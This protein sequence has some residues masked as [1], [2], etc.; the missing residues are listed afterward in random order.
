M[1]K[2]MLIL[3]ASIFWI[4][5][6]AFSQQQAQAGG[7]PLTLQRGNKTTTIKPGRRMAVVGPAEDSVIRGKLIT[8]TDSIA[9]QLAERGYTIQVSKVAVSDVREI[10]RRRTGW[11]LVGFYF[12]F[13]AF[14]AFQS[15]LFL[16]LP[17]SV[18]ILTLLQIFFG[19]IV[20]ALCFY[21]GFHKYSIPPWRIQ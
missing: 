13:Q 6:S 2:T 18:L 12:L 21:L 19:V 15:G 7:E 8:A 10:H 11:K 14:F 5:V 9:V 4:V 17:G 3:T 20:I 16:F 1:G